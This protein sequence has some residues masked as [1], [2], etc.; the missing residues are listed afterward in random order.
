MK[1][2]EE[3]I[4]ITGPNAI[5]YAGI[6]L[7]Y[8]QFA[9]IGIDQEENFRKSEEFVQKALEINPELMEAHFVYGQYFY[10]FRSS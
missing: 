4:D 3:G 5:F 6:A 10:A 2:L 8:F 1:L 7:A 9:N